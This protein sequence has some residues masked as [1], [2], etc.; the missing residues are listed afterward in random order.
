[1]VNVLVDNPLFLA[2]FVYNG[3]RNYFYRAIRTVYF[4]NST[5]C[6]FMLVVFVVRHNYLTTETLIHNKG[7]AV[8]RILLGDIFPWSEKILCSNFHTG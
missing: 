6:A 7:I 8:F 3:F 1:M 2:F 5:S 4:A